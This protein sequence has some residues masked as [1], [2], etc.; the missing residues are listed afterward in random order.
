MDL[1]FFSCHILIIFSK[2]LLSFFLFSF[3]LWVSNGAR[4]KD[5]KDLNLGMDT[6]MALLKINPLTLVRGI[7]L[8]LDSYKMR[9]K[10][11]NVKIFVGA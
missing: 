10:L 5:Y 1:A 9:F 8:S 3:F 4:E 6:A 7:S 2:N 11:L